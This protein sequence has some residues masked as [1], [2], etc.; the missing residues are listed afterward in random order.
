MVTEIEKE[1]PKV[2][3]TKGTFD[4]SRLTPP[5]REALAIARAQ[6]VEPI[7]SLAD[8][9]LDVEPELIDELIEEIAAARRDARKRPYKVRGG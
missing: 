9:K 6:K 7:R 5:Q 8:L 1:R 2:K 3:S 4:E